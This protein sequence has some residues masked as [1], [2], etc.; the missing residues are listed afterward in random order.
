MSR[1]LGYAD[2]YWEVVVDGRDPGGGYRIFLEERR[3][4]KRY[5][6]STARNEKEMN[7]TCRALQRDL[8]LP[9]EEFEA[10]YGVR[11]SPK[12]EMQPEP[13]SA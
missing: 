7:L 12:T 5:P 1:Y 10:R 2:Y 9:E 8:C 4:G 11:L 13:A 3:T 6:H